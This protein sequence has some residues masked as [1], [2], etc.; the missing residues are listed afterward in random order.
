MVALLAAQEDRDDHTARGTFAGSRLTAE[1]GGRK[2]AATPPGAPVT[3]QRQH[4]RDTCVP[5]AALAELSDAE[6]VQCAAINYLVVVIDGHGR[7]L[8]CQGEGRLA[9]AHRVEL[10]V[11]KRFP[12][13]YAGSLLER[14]LLR[15][16]LHAAARRGFGLETGCIL[17]RDLGRRHLRL[18]LRPLGDGGQG[19]L[20][21]IVDDSPR[22][23]AIE[24]WRADERRFRLLAEALTEH[25]LCMLD[26]YGVILDWNLG[27][28]RLSGHDAQHALARHFSMFFD[29]TALGRGIPSQLLDQSSRTGQAA[30]EITFMRRDGSTFPARIQ[31]DA[32]HDGDGRL[33]GF[34]LLV[35]DRRRLLQLEQRLR[36]A[37]QQAVHTHRLE[38][39]G[40]LTGG[41][42]HDFNNSLQGIISSLET[43]GVYLERGAIDQTRRYLEVALETAIRAGSLT[44]RLLQLARRQS[45]TDQYTA[46]NGVLHSMRDLLGRVLGDGV[47]LELEVDERIPPMICDAAQLES[48]I[49]N[50]AINARDAMAGRGRLAIASRLV[51][52]AS[53]A[54]PASSGDGAQ[55]E[56]SVRDNGPGMSEDIRQ[57]VFEP[58]FTTKPSGQ[59]TGLGLAMV[60]DFA[61]QHG[62][63]VDIQSAPGAGTTVI[64]RLPCITAGAVSQRDPPHQLH[65]RLPGLRILLV[66]DQEAIRKAV[67]TRLRQL[68]ATVFAA[69]CGKEAL[70]MLATAA[71][72]DVLI[73]D[74]DLPDFDG[75]ALCREARARF[76][77]LRVLLT[78]GY[79]DG[80]LLQR[81][82]LENAWHTLVKPFDMHALLSKLALLLG[83]Q[84][85]LA[86]LDAPP[87]ADS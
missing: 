32:V 46:V 56:I 64:L 20:L 71:A 40:Q 65:Q 19:H 69:S 73:S 82:R 41:I 42:A 53:T 37:D 14:R 45:P 24:Y 66:E 47:T 34:A 6:R 39:L 61:T 72:M 79:V 51:E 18:S 58:F 8:D 33:S 3:P 29:E 59:G 23:R 30:A 43:A 55:V 2:Q 49:L 25:A 63:A 13:L 48:A 36:E 16:L 67:A 78:T 15:G 11:G 75:I 27:I 10:L 50:L 21:T 70:R 28:E 44:R 7:I 12:A 52:A 81:E 87:H 35:Q 26:P 80:E 9:G 85:D 76:S 57:R 54:L 86:A 38:A 17:H 62:G 1:H 60:H 22:R 5:A 74:I 68:G 31:V 77:H 83:P 4:P 84:G